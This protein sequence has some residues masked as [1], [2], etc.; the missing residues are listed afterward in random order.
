I[1]NSIHWQDNIMEWLDS[2]QKLYQDGIGM[3]D[4]MCI[5]I[6]QQMAKAFPNYRIRIW[7]YDHRHLSGYD[8]H[9]KY[10]KQV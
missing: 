3:V 2:F 1:P 6:W 8:T 10:E 5:T 7:E 4:S 9:P